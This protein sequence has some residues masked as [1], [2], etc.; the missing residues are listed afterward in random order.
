M[1]IVRNNIPFVVP[2]DLTADE[3]ERAIANGDAVEVKAIKINRDT[4]HANPNADRPY[5]F[6][7]GQIVFPGRGVP[8][9][10]CRDLLAVK[11]QHA[12]SNAEVINS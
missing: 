11:T 4:I 10:V 5:S 6:V 12:S 7:A 8:E 1:L 3:A 9:N 2:M